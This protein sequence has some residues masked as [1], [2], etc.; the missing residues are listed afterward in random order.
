M[1]LTSFDFNRWNRISGVLGAIV[2]MVIVLL[3]LVGWIMLDDL[4]LILLLAFCVITPLAI[5]HVALPKSGRLLGE[6]SSLVLF[7]QP[8]A[9]LIGGASLLFG[10]GLLAAAA[11]I[12]WFLFTVF[13]ALIGGLLLLQKNDQHLADV[14]LAMA[15]A[16]VP[17]GGVWLVLDRLGSQPL[18]FGQITVLL[19][20]VHFHFIT[21][22]A[23]IITGLTGRSIHA[24]QREIP[25][26]IYRVAALCMLINPL[27][28]AS[29]ITL[30]QIT[31]VRFLESAA[32]DL[33][34]LSMI[35]IAILNLRYVIPRTV[36]L[37]ARMLLAFSSIAVVITMLLAG[38]YALGTATRLWT[39]TI[40][41]MIAEH[42]WINA[43]VFGL[44]GLLGWRLRREPEKE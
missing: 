13:M 6:I 9:T 43:L 34:A 4:K 7:L 36:P 1:S 5:P 8:F 25:W 33:L 17:I 28:V 26:K 31:G 38:A 14:C 23:L 35:L 15:L 40:S 16:Y 10:R 41:Q 37:Y 30:T 27:L 44:C 19:T 2:W 22:A 18:G 3:R 20:A 12:V 32:A 24:T 21:L 42:G 29:G 11:A 39:I